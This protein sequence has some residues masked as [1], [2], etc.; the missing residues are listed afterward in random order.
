MTR[1]ATAGASA[2]DGPLERARAARER[3][4]AWLLD[5]IGSDGGPVGWQDGNGWSRV[6]W[7]LSLCGRTEEGAAVLDWAA[8]NALAPDGGFRQGPARGTGRFGAYQLGHLAIG[9]WRLERYDIANDLLGR[10]AA[11]QD[12]KTGGILVCPDGSSRLTDLL[13][14]AQVGIAALGA[15]RD[16]IAR[17]VR[18]WI[19]CLS[20]QQ[21]DFPNRLFNM[22][23]GDALVLEP[24]EG[25]A[26]IAVTDFTAPRQTYFYP[27]IAA[28]FLAQY[29][30]ADGD[31]EAL[32]LGHRLL[33][34]NIQGCSEQFDDPD[35]VQICKF[36]W[37]A[38]AMQI[39]DPSAAYEPWLVRM[40]AWIEAHQQPDGSWIPSAFVSAS[41]SLVERMTK[42]AEHAMELD[43]VIGALGAL[44]ARAAQ[45]ASD[46]RR[47]QIEVANTVAE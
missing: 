7:T 11:L 41:P 32:A 47:P 26:W 1:V 5:H 3:S 25:M 37:G 28:V 46:T 9:A 22:R 17:G 4:L 20:A 14:T 6:P 43:A 23:D 34:A 8:R 29:A 42:T 13:C 21:P 19:A 39:A 40:A 15:G 10:L 24:P 36:G 30:M 12:P 27:G 44:R 31:A 38:A 18:A 35:S 45:A 16:D 33:S 2:L